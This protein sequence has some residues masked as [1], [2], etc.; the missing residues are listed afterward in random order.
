[1]IILL[2]V[3]CPT[4]FIQD[5][6][7][8]HVPYRYLLAFFSFYFAYI[9]IEIATKRHSFHAVTQHFISLLYSVPEECKKIYSLLVCET[10]LKSIISYGVIY[11]IFSLYSTKSFKTFL[12]ELIF[13]S[14]GVSSIV[15][16]SGITS[17]LSTINLNRVIRILCVVCAACLGFYAI[18]VLTDQISYNRVTLIIVMFPQYIFADLMGSIL[19]TE[20]SLNFTFL[21]IRIITFFGILLSSYIILVKNINLKAY[22]ILLKIENNKKENE[23]H[24]VLEY[25]VKLLPI[26][27]L[28][29]RL[30]VTREMIQIFKEKN[31]LFMVF[32]QTLLASAVM[33]LSAMNVER[34][35]VYVGLVVAIGYV[36][37]IISL[38]SIPREAKTI[39]VFKI[40]GVKFKDFLIAKFITNYLVT[41]IISLLTFTLYVIPAVMIVRI[42]F[43]T[44]ITIYLLSLISIIPLSILIGLIISASMPYELTEKKKRITYKFNGMEGAFLVV[45]VFL[46]VVPSYIFMEQGHEL[47][48]FICFFSY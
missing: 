17:I 46:G 42:S 7:S 1:V 11:G 24:S 19:N 45:L 41:L 40:I 29:I 38:Y 2:L 21:F 33:L 9:L 48:I 12:I 10:I 30:L 36:G 13:L 44:L 39:W 26:L 35:A 20:K 5:T 15:I 8:I 34:S 37:L 6:T 4:I 23:K 43:H 28:N 25:I 3:I 22:D 47:I 31:A 16:I 27:P 32:W 14:L 18:N